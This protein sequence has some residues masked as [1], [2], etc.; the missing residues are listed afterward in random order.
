MASGAV[1]TE[2][3]GHAC[4]HSECARRSLIESVLHDDVL[5][6]VLRHVINEKGGFRRG[7]MLF[8]VNKLLM[9]LVLECV[10]EIYSNLRK[11][12]AEL[13]PSANYMTM[14]DDLNDKMRA[15]LVDWLI[16]VPP[17]SASCSF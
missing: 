13:M 9:R 10:E 6:A 16:E 8:A 2:G 3:V 5:C 11:K 14:Q 7:G 15:I 12:E 17:P 1:G 4:A